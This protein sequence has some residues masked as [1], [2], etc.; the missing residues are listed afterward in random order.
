MQTKQPLGLLLV[1]VVYICMHLCVW[2]CSGWLWTTVAMSESELLATAGMDALVSTTAVT[3]QQSSLTL[4]I[5]T[6]ES[7]LLVAQLTSA[8][9]RWH[10]QLHLYC[11]MA[12]RVFK[13]K[14]LHWPDAELFQE[15]PKHGC[16]V[17]GWFRA[18]AD[19]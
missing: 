10:S 4:R 18:A 15:H 5:C 7:W 14:G 19:A 9:S 2:C 3:V 1:S 6:L 17:F 8:C 13:S 11:S 16:H 12:F